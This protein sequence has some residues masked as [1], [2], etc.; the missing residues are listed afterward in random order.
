MEKQELPGIWLLEAFRRGGVDADRLARAIPV[1][2]R[3]MLQAPADLLPRD[4]NTILDACA[5]LSGDGDFGLHMVDFVDPATLGAYG[6]LLTNA[7]T[8]GRFL[9]IAEQFYPTF[10]RGSGLSLQSDGVLGSLEYRV[11]GGAAASG[12]HDNEWS[13]GFFVEFIARK[14]GDGWVPVRTEFTHR[15]PADTTAL[16]RVFGDDIRFDAPRTAFAFETAIL[17]RRINA[18][19]PEL[20]RVLTDQAE[21]LLRN[22][23]QPDAFEATVRLQILETLE[24]GSASLDTVARNLALSR[25][26]LKRRLAASGRT[27]RELRD[28]IVEEVSTR[29]LTETEIEVSAIAAKVGYA[30]LSSFDRAFKRITGMSPSAYRRDRSG[31]TG[32]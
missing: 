12:R 25:S 20:L 2:F 7:P 6:Y 29:A 32:A 19:D 27:F 5:R 22:L 28:S 18:A 3:R 15:E 24:Q 30:E 4:V 9:Q 10:Y 8:I 17:D 21:I 23:A 26:T 13:L 31:S 16:R 14:L 11:H 1:E